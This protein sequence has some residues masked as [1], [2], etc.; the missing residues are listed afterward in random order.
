[1]KVFIFL[2]LSITINYVLATSQIINKEKFYDY[3][4]NILGQCENAIN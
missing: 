1:M 2:L 3:D 4:T